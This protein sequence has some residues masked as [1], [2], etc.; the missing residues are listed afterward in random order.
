[1]KIDPQFKALIPPLAPEEL[2]QLETNLLAD[3]CRDPLVT[4]KGTLLDGHNRYEICQ[5]HKLKFKTKEIKLSDRDA[6]KDWIETNQLGRRNLP[7]HILSVLRG[8]IYN[9]R[10]AKHGGDR[11]SKGK[12]CPLIPTADAVAKET[13]V[14]PRTI[15]NDARLAAEVAADPELKAALNDRTEFKQV[16]RAKKKKAHAELIERVAKEKKDNPEQPKGPFDII[17]ADPPW[18]YEHCEANNREIENHYTT[19]TLEEIFKHAPNVKKDAILFLWATAPKLA[20]AMRVID[21][22]GFTYRSGAVWDKEVIGMGYWFRVQHEHL[23]VAV[24]GKPKAPPESERV[25]S[26]FRQK[27][28]K[29]SA[30]P[31]F[32]HEWIERAY[33]LAEKCEMYC[34]KPRPGWAAWGNEV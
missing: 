19:A 4:W 34:R 3:G 27:R 13:G 32:F 33:P 28:G 14:S 8:N 23:L 20:E 17:L 6:A 5:R 22:W 7:A 24:K 30:K 12:S 26:L 15:K 31:Q 2:A 11:K 29:H 21:A 10:K 16:R 9:R 1:M 25:S 18:R